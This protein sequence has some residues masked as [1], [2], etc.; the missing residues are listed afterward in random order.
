[1]WFAV[2]FG[3]QSLREGSTTSLRISSKYHLYTKM[4]V[5][6]RNLCTLLPIPDDSE[7]LLI[8]GTG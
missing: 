5:F 2:K 4:G 1:M 3:K 7:I 8:D 6:A